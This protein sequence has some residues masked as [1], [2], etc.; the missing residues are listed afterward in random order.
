MHELPRLLK[1]KFESYKLSLVLWLVY[2]VVLVPHKN[3]DHGWPH[4]ILVRSVPGR[5]LSP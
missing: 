1:H 2:L 5:R 4:R 3:Q